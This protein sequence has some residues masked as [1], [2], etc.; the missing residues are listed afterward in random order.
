MQ[1]YTHFDAGSI[2]VVSIENHHA[3]LNIRQDT[4]SDFLQWFYFQVNLKTLNSCTFSIHNAGKTSY[5]KGWFNYRPCI[6]YD[7]KNWKRLDSANFNGE[8]LEF[9]LTPEDQQFYL[10]YFTPFSYEQHLDLIAKAQAYQHVTHH[11]LGQTTQGR[12][13]DLLHIS[14]TDKPK[15]KIWIIARQHPGETMAEWFIKGVVEKLSQTVEPEINTLLKTSAFY[16]VP[17]M[18]VDGAHLGNLRVNAKGVNLN[19]EWLSPSIEKSPEVFYVLEKIK[20]T[21]VD[22]FLDIHGDEEIPYNFISASEGIPN[23]SNEI[24]N[25]E[26]QFI[27]NLLKTSNE[28][29]RE[30]G[31]AIDEK[32]KADLSMA[33]NYISNA[34]LCPSMTIEMPFKDNDN[35]P[36]AITGW[37][38]ER[39][40]QFGQ[41]TLKAIYQL[42]KTDLESHSRTH[43]QII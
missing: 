24:F 17:N 33:S 25:A 26:Q 13:I 10:A 32:G 7:R 41:D 22:L 28:F 31:Y 38:A 6:S 12:N 11:V 3:K 15:K 9:T 23:L 1:I 14:K 16:I 36:N 2:E 30:H 27:H 43:D 35:A 4:H 39:S 42:Y 5:P 40:A 20:E 18:N 21:G 8:A 19:R 34:F 37:S 29:Q